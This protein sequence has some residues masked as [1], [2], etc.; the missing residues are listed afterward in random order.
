MLD[1]FDSG[2][3]HSAF[4]GLAFASEHAIYASEGNSGKISLFDWNSERRR[5]ID[6]NQKGF[7]DSYTGD[8]ALDEVRGILYA[9]DQANF[10]VAVIDSKTRQVLTSVKTGR[11]P[12]AMA[13]SADRQKL[14]V[15]N[16]GMFEYQA[17]PGVNL[18]DFRRTGLPF[19]A[20]GFPSEESAEGT[21]RATAKGDIKV[22]GLGDPNVQE[23]NSVC[24]IDVSTPA[25]AKV[26]KF[27]RTGT[28]Y[29]RRHSGRE[30]A[31]GNTGHRRCGLRQ[32]FA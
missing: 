10:R 20:F 7:D 18:E 6:L 28:A 17:L 13:L 31:G 22:P 5:V 4:M 14:Y 26:E 11:L 12:F 9:V 30:C 21:D 15:T 27:I 16:L 25:A 3:W 2:D 32:Q 1:Q 29:S 24:V 8:L 23:S 19:P